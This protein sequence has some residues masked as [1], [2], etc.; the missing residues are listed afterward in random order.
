[1]YRA[2]YVNTQYSDH[3]V[4]HSEYDGRLYIIT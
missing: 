1:M 4:A 3:F 2:A